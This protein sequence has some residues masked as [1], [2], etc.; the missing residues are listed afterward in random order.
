VAVA[1]LIGALTV[2]GLVVM[3][4]WYVARGKNDPAAIRHHL[5]LTSKV[6]AHLIVAKATPTPTVMPS[7]PAI[8][9]PPATRATAATPTLTPIQT[10]PTATPLP[11]PTTQP[12]S[13]PTKTAPKPPVPRPSTPPPPPVG[14][15]EAQ[16]VLR[17]TNN[18]RTSA[19]CAPLQLSS[20]LDNAAQEHANDM[21]DNHYFAHNSQDGRTPLDRMRAA[22]YT[23]SST[24]ENVATG[25]R[26]AAAVVN[27]W[28]NSDTDRANILN[29]SYT[30]MGVGYN[31]GRIKDKWN[32]GTWVQDLGT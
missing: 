31:N 10:H 20:A 17:L 14:S 23:G 22:G 8:S 21:V 1:P 27:A 13:H 19:G 12:T 32:R 3:G 11:K 24:A 30:L 18:E 29:C 2:L 28:M 7:R 16:E 4:G 15:P 9:T 5:P 25:S 26:D 6:T